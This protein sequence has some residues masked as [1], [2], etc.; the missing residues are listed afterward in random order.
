MHIAQA[1]LGILGANGIVGAG[2]R[3]PWSRTRS[4]GRGRGR[5]R[6]RVLWRGRR[7]LRGL[8]R[9]PGARRRVAGSGHLRVRE[10]RLRRIHAERRSVGRPSPRNGQEATACRRTQSTAGMCWRWR[11]RCEQQSRWRAPA[12]DR[13]SWRCALTVWE[14][15]TKVTRSPTV[16][17]RSPTTGG[18]STTLWQVWVGVRAGRSRRSGRNGVGLSR[19][20]DGRSRGG[21]PRCPYPDPSTVEEYVGG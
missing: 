2:I 21:R 4:V 18:P 10:Q 7:S 8:P 9:G 15:I 14:G 1:D 12:A 6:R 5:C 20:R 13:R 3:L 19:S 17:R 16:T 11:P